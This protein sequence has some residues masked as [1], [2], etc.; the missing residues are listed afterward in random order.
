MRVHINNYLTVGP[1]VGFPVGLSVGMMVG[2]LM[3]LIVGAPVDFLEGPVGRA[4]DDPKGA[5]EGF[6]EGTF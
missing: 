6:L 3:G 4:V 2:A 1:K 5:L